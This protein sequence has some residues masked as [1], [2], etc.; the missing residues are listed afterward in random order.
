[1]NRFG[2]AAYCRD[3]EC[4]HLLISKDVR[5]SQIRNE[6]LLALACGYGPASHIFNLYRWDLVVTSARNRKEANIS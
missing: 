6:I 3:D 2:P 5:A 4:N 1:M